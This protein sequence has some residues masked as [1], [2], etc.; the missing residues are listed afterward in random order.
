MSD[1][2]A[3]P[4]QQQQGKVVEMPKKCTAEGCKNKDVRMSFCQEHFAWYKEGLITAKG[5][6]V[7]DFD[8]K[9]QSFMHRKSRTA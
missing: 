8:K 6:Q 7:K 9:F 4:Q 3:Q 5:K 1:K 2:K